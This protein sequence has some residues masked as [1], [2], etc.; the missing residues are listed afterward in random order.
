MVCRV[1]VRGCTLSSA[2]ATA[3]RL[4][5]ELTFSFNVLADP[6]NL[7]AQLI[8]DPAGTYGELGARSSLDIIV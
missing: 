5:T 8:Y 2:N 4:V 6:P 1:E 3:H 7:Q